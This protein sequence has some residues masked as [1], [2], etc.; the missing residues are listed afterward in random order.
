MLVADECIEKVDPGELCVY[1]QQCQGGSNC[2]KGVCECPKGQRISHGKCI[3]IDES[4]IIKCPLPGQIPYSERGTKK[5]QHNISF[6]LFNNDVYN[7]AKI[8]SFFFYSFDTVQQQTITVQKDL[9]ANIVFQY[10]KIFAVGGQLHE[11]NKLSQEQNRQLKQQMFV[12][13]E[14]HLF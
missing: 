2:T 10:K 14:H 5:V 13:K 1:N 8:I 7:T 3:V 12:I 4:E 9:V 11:I 6:L